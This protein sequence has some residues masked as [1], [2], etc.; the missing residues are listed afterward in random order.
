V[1]PIRRRYRTRLRPVRPYDRAPRW[2]V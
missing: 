1:R 2:K